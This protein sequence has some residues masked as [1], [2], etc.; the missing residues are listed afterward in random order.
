VEEEAEGS[1][2]R[3]SHARETWRDVNLGRIWLDAE[4]SSGSSDSCNESNLEAAGDVGE[5]CRTKDVCH[6]R[7]QRPTKATMAGACRKSWRMLLWSQS[8]WTARD[9]FCDGERSALATRFA[10]TCI[11]SPSGEVAGPGGSRTELEASGGPNPKRAMAWRL[12]GMWRLVV[13]RP[14]NDEG[15]MVVTAG[16]CCTILGDL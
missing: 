7:T 11:S 15:E 2:A 5:T 4:A 12:G 1:A 6:H 3:C 8:W 9:A 13:E 14:A 10:A 16:A